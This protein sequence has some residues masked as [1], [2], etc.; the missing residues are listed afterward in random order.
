MIVSSGKSDG[1]QIGCRPSAASIQP[2]RTSSWLNAWLADQDPEPTVVRVESPEPRNV[3][4]GLWP[5]QVNFDSRGQVGAL[6]RHASEHAREVRARIDAGFTLEYARGSMDL[7][8]DASQT[9]YD[10]RHVHR[11]SHRPRLR[12]QVRKGPR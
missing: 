7:V 8:E 2:S 12:H 9:L 5:N 3:G 11:S 1:S 6:A 10:K 4:A